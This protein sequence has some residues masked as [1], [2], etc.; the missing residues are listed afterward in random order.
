MNIGYVQFY[1]SGM[2]YKINFL[3]LISTH[4]IVSLH[5]GSEISGGKS[6]W[7]VAVT[8]LVANLL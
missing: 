8:V 5:K 7:V 6:K 3:I 2:T 4:L 1:Y